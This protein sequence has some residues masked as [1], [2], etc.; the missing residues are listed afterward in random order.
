MI[1]YTEGAASPSIPAEG[2]VAKRCLPYAPGK[3]SSHVVHSSRNGQVR[4][5]ET[6][7]GPAEDDSV[8]VG[9]SHS[10]PVR[11]GVPAIPEYGTR[12]EVDL[13]R[14]ELVLG[15]NNHPPSFCYP[16]RAGSDPQRTW[17]RQTVAAGVMDSPRAFFK[18][19]NGL[20]PHLFQLLYQA[21]TTQILP[22]AFQSYASW[23]KGVLK[24]FQEILVLDDREDVSRPQRDA[25]S[26]HALFLSSKP[27][28]SADLCGGDGSYRLP[29]RS[30]WYCTQCQGV[31]RTNLAHQALSQSWLLPPTIIASLSKLSS[32]PGLSILAP[33]FDSQVGILFPQSIPTWNISWFSIATLI[34]A[35]KILC[36][37]KTLEVYRSCSGWP[38]ILEISHRQLSSWL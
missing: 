33:K 11:N 4:T 31:A 7:C 38:F 17:K 16:A 18:K 10:C 36:L 6:P 28:G 1:C 19:A 5:Q 22:K 3:T 27:S 20:H 35:K 21:F 30:G 15:G 12:M 2:I 23:M 34:D 14:C 24:H 25:R 9:S 13:L 29:H 32:K 37:W 8:V 26:P